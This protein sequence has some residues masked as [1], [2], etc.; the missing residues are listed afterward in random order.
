[1]GKQTMIS[2]VRGRG[3]SGT[4]THHWWLQRLS[5][6]ALIPLMIWFLIMA[7]IQ[8]DYS[9]NAM[10]ALLKELHNSVLLT[11]LIAS[12]LYHSVLGL[13]VIIEDYI[14]CSIIK[15][16]SLIALKLMGC[17][18]F[19]VSVFAILVILFS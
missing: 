9:P 14:H 15:L 3:A 8:H 12:G 19:I 16:L 7:F 11:L 17:F 6:V 10:Q 18:A 2:R 5:A 1:M 13:Q 4:G